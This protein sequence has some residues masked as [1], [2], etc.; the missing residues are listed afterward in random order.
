MLADILK[1]AERVKE[2]IQLIREKIH[3]NPEIGNK[4]FKTAELI[5]E[6]LKSHGIE[7]ERILD[8]AVVGTLR[9]SREGKTVALRADMDALPVQETSG[10]LFASKTDGMMHACGHDVHMAAALGAAIILSNNKDKINGTVK[11]FFQPDEEG[12]GGAARMIGCGCLD[13]V[14]AIFGGH[15]HPEIPLG[16]IGIRYGKFYA[17]SN[18]FRIVIRGKSAHGATPEL[19]IDALAAAAELVCK[20]KKIP[21]NFPNEKCVV[22]VGKLESG[23]RGNIIADKAY[24][25]GIMRCLGEDTRQAV[26]NL[27]Y[28]SVEEI[29]EKTGVLVEVEI[30][31][32]YCGIVNNNEMTSLVKT[33]VEKIFGKE[34]LIEIE[35][36]TMTTEDFGI[37]LESVPGS[38]Y[39]IGAGCDLPLHNSGFLPDSMAA[40]YAAAAHTAVITS[41]LDDE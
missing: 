20:L 29:K 12:F 13:G 10:A 5:E 15:V 38:F 3:M 41:F 16:S 8:T 30:L 28:S 9:G 7:T 22:T 40:V 19:G 17:A 21:D 31:D 37:F 23:I 32:S 24:L 4:E 33:S 25:I 39:H 11:F 18:T 1:E 36:P 34:R 27:V 14:E 35:Q 2:E 6:C 26:K